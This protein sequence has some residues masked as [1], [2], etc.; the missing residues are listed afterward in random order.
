M[1]NAN[2][3]LSYQQLTVL[4]LLKSHIR[5]QKDAIATLEN[6]AQQNF[7]VINIIIGIVAGLNLNGGASDT[8]P[9][10][11]S[12]R[13][14]L[15]AVFLG[16]VAV[17]V[18]SLGALAISR[19]ATAPMKVSVKNTV[20]WSETDVKHLFDI[21]TR[22]YVGIYRHNERIVKLK[23]RSVKWSYTIFVIVIAAI[24]VEALGLT[25]F[26]ID[27]VLISVSALRQLAANRYTAPLGIILVCLLF[28]SSSSA[29]FCLLSRMRVGVSAAV[30]GLGALA[31]RL[32]RQH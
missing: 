25:A 27:L 31:K 6:K 17:V 10:I 28:L 16:Y 7:T 8:L 12:G 29:R 19:Q 11:V 18:L 32:R 5:A 30:N 22:S 9:N 26:V 24:F 2:D 4:E 14:M 3:S 15:I 13:P 20:E 1:A 23:G 21:L